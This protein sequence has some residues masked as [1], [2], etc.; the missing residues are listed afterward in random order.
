MEALA[1]GLQFR[2]ANLQ[3]HSGRIATHEETKEAVP[4]RAM[5][6]AG[7]SGKQPPDLRYSQALAIT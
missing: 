3:D 2:A 6:Q 5:W 4:A 1:N 7:D